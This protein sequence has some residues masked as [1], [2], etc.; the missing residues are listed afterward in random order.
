MQRIG[1]IQIQSHNC[2]QKSLDEKLT[3][4]WSKTADKTQM[5]GHF[6][7]SAQQNLQNLNPQM[8]ICDLVLECDEW[9]L[10]SNAKAQGEH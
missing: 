9:N 2:R 5:K 3:Q 7:S 1:Q 8:T 4:P 6:E 10:T